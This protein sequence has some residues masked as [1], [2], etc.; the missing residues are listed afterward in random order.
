[1]EIK[2]TIARKGEYLSDGNGNRKLFDSRKEAEEFKAEHN[3]LSD[4]IV[5]G[6]LDPNLLKHIDGIEAYNSMR[7]GNKIYT[8]IF[9]LDLVLCK[10]E[11][12]KFDDFTQGHF[13]FYTEK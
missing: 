11:K 8:K 10:P 3:S 1:M 4:A 2:Y 5:L 9:G 7:N 6:Y 13:N 12:W